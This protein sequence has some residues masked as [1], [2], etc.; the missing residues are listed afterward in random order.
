M[1]VIAYFLLSQFLWAM[2]FG[3]YHILFSLV[4]MFLLFKCWERLSF[5]QS[6]SL[7]VLTHM[8]ALFTVICVV[9]IGLIDLWKYEYVPINPEVPHYN[10]WYASLSLGLTYAVIQSI[11]LCFLWTRY[12]WL[13]AWRTLMIVFLSNFLSAVLVYKLLPSY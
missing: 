11:F 1:E 3:F 13:H 7:S 9:K 5:V 2:T 12:P 10:P 6:I 4:I 8:I